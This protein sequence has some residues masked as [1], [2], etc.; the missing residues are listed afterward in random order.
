MFVVRRKRDVAVT[1]LEGVELG[2]AVFRQRNQANPDAG[3]RFDQRR[4]L[5]GHNPIDADRRCN[6]LEFSYRTTAGSQQ[7]DDTCCCKEC[8][9][10]RQNEV[11][12]SDP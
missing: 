9:P 7:H 5:F 12:L 4:N 8:P 1:G 6:Q 11:P 10:P 2:K 3:F